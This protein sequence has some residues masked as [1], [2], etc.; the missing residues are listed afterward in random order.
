[1][2]HAITEDLLVK[3]VKDNFRH[4][5]IETTVYKGEVTHLVDIKSLRA[6]CNFLKTDPDLRMNFLCDVLGVDYFRETPRFEVVYHF[7]SIQRK[8]RI[9]VKVRVAENEAVPSVTHLWPGADWPEREVYDMFGIVFEGHPNMKRI[10][11]AHDWVGHPLRKDYPLRGY[12]DRYNP[13]G[14]EKPE[15][16]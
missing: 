3:K 6:V 15:E 8:H 12:K 1:M 16:I 11:L 14:E 7:Y 4:D 13:Y 5:I 2:K 9:R 10:Y